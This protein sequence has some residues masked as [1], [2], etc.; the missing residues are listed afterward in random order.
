VKA[1]SDLYCPLSGEV[2]EVNG[3]LGDNPEAINKEPYE[4]GWMIKLKLTEPSELDQL[5]DAAGYQ[6]HIGE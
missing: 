6:A 2:T 1:A 3:D 4:G 5:M